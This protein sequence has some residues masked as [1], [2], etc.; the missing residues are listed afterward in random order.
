MTIV[1]PWL[2]FAGGLI[3]MIYKGK[4][5]KRKFL[6]DRKAQDESARL[7]EEEMKSRQYPLALSVRE[8]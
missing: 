5:S 7:A 2:V 1:I 4:E 6:E 8:R 3:W